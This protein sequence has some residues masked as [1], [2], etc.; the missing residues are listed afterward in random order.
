MQNITEIRCLNDIRPVPEVSLQPLGAGELCNFLRVCVCARVHF[1]FHFRNDVCKNRV[2]YFMGCDNVSIGLGY[3]CAAL[4][5]N[6]V[7]QWSNR[8]NATTAPSRPNFEF[9][10][11]RLHWFIWKIKR[12]QARVLVHHRYE[13]LPVI[14]FNS[15][16]LSLVSCCK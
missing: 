4:I 5:V 11:I 7:M 14:E 8:R 2:L 10:K 1:L 12:R 6:L 16:C 13:L 15:I 9:A 3:L